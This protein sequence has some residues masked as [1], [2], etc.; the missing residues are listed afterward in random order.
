M[1]SLA[2]IPFAEVELHWNRPLEGAPGIRIRQLRGALAS[3]F[4]EDDLF[5][6][7]DPLTGRLL[8]RYPRVQYRWHQGRGVVS[9]WAEAAGRL[10]LLPWLDLNLVLGDDHVLVADAALTLRQG[11][12][13]VSRQLL[14]YQTQSPLLLFNQEN[15][16]RYQLLDEAGRQAERDRLLVSN[17]LIGLRGLGVT[18]PEHLYASFVETRPRQCHYKGERLLGLSGRFVT[19]AHLPDGFAVGHAVSHGFGSIRGFAPSSPTH[20]P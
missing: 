8:Y 17:L 14:H 13:G 18:F 10:L 1:H 15:Y 5:H 6:Q 11:Q 7:H 9:G 16:Q 2:Q 19:N 12:F 20:L 3:A 4:H